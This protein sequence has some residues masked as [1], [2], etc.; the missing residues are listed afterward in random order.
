MRLKL[1]APA[2]VSRRNLSRHTWAGFRAPALGST[3]AAKE[4]LKW[5]ALPSSFAFVL[6][7]AAVLI[8][9]IVTRVRRRQPGAINQ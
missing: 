3:S 7:T 4:S 5:L 8:L 6:A 1:H 9:L 2:L